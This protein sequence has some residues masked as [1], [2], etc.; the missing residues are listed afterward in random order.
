MKLPGRSLGTSAGGRETDL[1]LAAKP[2]L[3]S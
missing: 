2:A 1:G 3:L